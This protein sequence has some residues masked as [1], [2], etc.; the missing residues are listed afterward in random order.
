MKEHALAND[1]KIYAG[2]TQSEEVFRL[3]LV[4]RYSGEV[5]LSSLRLRRV[6]RIS[7]WG[8]DAKVD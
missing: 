8:G 3:I 6:N 1:R 2:A 7:D 5:D 4:S